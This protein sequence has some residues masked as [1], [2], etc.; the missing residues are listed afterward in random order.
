[1]KFCQRKVYN[2][3]GVNKLE[4]S[5]HYITLE[6]VKQFHGKEFTDKWLELIKDKPLVKEGWYYYDDYRF[7]ARQ[8]DS[9]LHPVS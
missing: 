7:A 9:Y 8:T 6:D 2:Y 1:M 4:T 5:I 3:I